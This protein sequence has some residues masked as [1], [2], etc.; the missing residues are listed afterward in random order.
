MSAVHISFDPNDP[1]DCERAVTEMMYIL[2]EHLGPAQARR[3]LAEATPARRFI[4]ERSNVHLMALYVAF[5]KARRAT[6]RGFAT[7]YAKMNGTLPRDQRG[8]PRGSTNPVAL[9]KQIRRQKKRAAKDRFVGGFRIQ[10]NR[11]RCR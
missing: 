5:W 11:H 3:L 7:R 2:W 6:V 10:Q 8:G 9:E 1:E 4:G